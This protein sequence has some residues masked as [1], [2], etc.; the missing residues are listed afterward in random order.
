MLVML[1]NFTHPLKHIVELISNN[2]DK[3]NFHKSQDIEPYPQRRN[4]FQLKAPP[5]NISISSAV[6]Y[7]VHVGWQQPHHQRMSQ[8]MM[9]RM[10]VESCIPLGNVLRLGGRNFAE[11]AAVEFLRFTNQETF[12]KFKTILKASAGHPVSPSSRWSVQRTKNSSE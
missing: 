6:Q 5:S 2:N 7:L 1:L 12:N 11:E 4:F 10:M 8:C 3:N 9:M